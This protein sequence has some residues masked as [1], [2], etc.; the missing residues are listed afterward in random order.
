[1]KKIINFTILMI[2]AVFLVA[3]DNKPE[4][5]THAT[6]ILYKYSNSYLENKTNPEAAVAKVY[7]IGEKIGEP[8]D[9]VR[10]G[11]EFIGWYKDKELQ[12][13]WN[14][15]EDVLETNMVLFAKWDFTPYKISLDFNGGWFPAN[16][17]FNGVYE[18]GEYYY[19]YRTGSTQAL[20]DAIKT[21]Y[22]FLGWHKTEEIKIG[23]KRE[24]RVDPAIS[25]DTT[26]YA[27]WELLKIIVRFDL[28]TES[29]SVTPNKIDPKV[30]EYNSK[31]NFESLKDSSGRVFLGWNTRKDGSGDYLY[32][33]DIFTYIN[34]MTVY[35]QWV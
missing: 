28:N 19:V 18:D 2:L 20:H 7:K 12:N 23:D 6:V 5:A 25:Q 4:E 27:H 21:G 17:S 32:N 29:T 35:A 16:S 30:V 8:D 11:Y 10:S 3:C 33:G 14:F 13:E 22:K 15:A 1:M 26:Y 34:A 9:P 24:T 31:I